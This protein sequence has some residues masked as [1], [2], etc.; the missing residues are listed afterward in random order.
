MSV[1]LLVRSFCWVAGRAC[2]LSLLFAACR[3]G[4]CS[5][6]ASV[7][8]SPSVLCVLVCSLLGS[9]HWLLLYLLSISSA[10]CSVRCSTRTCSCACLLVALLLVLSSSL[11][12]FGALVHCC[13]PWLPVGL[14]HPDALPWSASD[15]HSN[16]VEW[17]FAC[18]A[19]GHTAWYTCT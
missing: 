13:S 16:W 18:L 2:C 4:R 6:F 1:A 11:V 15:A 9:L 14:N 10:H 19:H 8:V 3:D 5:G 7:Y 12:V 17:H